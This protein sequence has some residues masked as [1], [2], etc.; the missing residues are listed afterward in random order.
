MATDFAAYVAEG[1]IHTRVEEY[2][3]SP[4]TN[5]S[6]QFIPG[7]FVV[8]DTSNDWCERAGSDPTP[9]LGLAEVKSD[10][11]GLLTP[12]GKIPVRR[13]YPG[14]VIAMCSATTPVAATHEGQQYGIARLSSGNWAV[15]VGD[16][17]NKRVQVEKVD[18]ARGIWFCTPIAA[19][20]GTTVA[21]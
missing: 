17:T 20:F 21:S 13:L 5:A 6:D 10:E 2:A 19:H 1:H 18:E 7:E 9:I 8:Y 16:T 11:A 3:V 14:V 15:D 4:S 12:N